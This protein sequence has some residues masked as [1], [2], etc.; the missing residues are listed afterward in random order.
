MH[1]PLR[2]FEKFSDEAWERHYR[3]FVY[4]DSRLKNTLGKPRPTKTDKVGRPAEYIPSTD[5][6]KFD[7]WAKQWDEPRFDNCV[8][9]PAVCEGALCGGD[10]AARVTRKIGTGKT[11]E[12][13]VEAALTTRAEFLAHMRH[14]SFYFRWQFARAT[15]ADIRSKPTCEPDI[16]YMQEA[17]E[18]ADRLLEFIILALRKTIRR[19]AWQ[20]AILPIKQKRTIEPLVH[21]G[22][23][24]GLNTNRRSQQIAHFVPSKRRNFRHKDHKHDDLAFDLGL[25]AGAFE[26]VTAPVMGFFLL[27]LTAGLQRQ[28]QRFQG[29]GEPAIADSTEC[30]PLVLLMLTL[31]PPQ[32]HCGLRLFL[33]LLAWLLRVRNKV[34]S[35]HL[36]VARAVARKFQG[37]AELEDL[38]QQGVLGLYK[39]LN[40]FDPEK[41]SFRRWPIAPSSR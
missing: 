33:E 20:A 36:W 39:A 14:P 2:Q 21:G 1:A 6:L 24:I 31:A 17:G 37:Q 4:W 5:P 32:N 12:Q 40:A 18:V 16:T 3:E 38:K 28:E 30:D 15:Y 41:E 27:W 29:V 9:I 25:I 23:G 8:F 11:Y 13:L 34:V 7:P 35:A 19:G 10:V 22:L 26:Y